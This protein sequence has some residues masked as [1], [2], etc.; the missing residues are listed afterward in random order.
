MGFKQRLAAAP[1]VYAPGAYDAITARMIERA[2]FEAI[3]MTGASIAAASL[4]QPDIGLV[5]FAEVLDVVMRVRDCV[6][7][8]LV[9]DADNGYGNALNVQR[10]VRLLERAGAT[11]IQ[12]EDQTSPKRCGHLK[13]KDVISADEMVGKLRAALDA[14][15]SEETLIIARTDAIAV[16]GF[17]AA[18]D[19]V[20]RFVEAGADI[21]FVEALRTAEE[22]KVVADRFGDRVPLMINMVEGGSTPLKPVAELSQMNFR[23]VIAPGAIMRAVLPVMEELLADM[24]RD[25]STVAWRDRMID[26]AGMNERVELERLL[27]TGRRYEPHGHLQD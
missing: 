8:P 14:R 13:G 20:E 24:R 1:A 9:V 23:L 27:A 6:S 7:L 19:R 22:M 17:D 3:F 25:G 18:I 10:T 12:L 16:A 2:G 26:L 11:A 21:L 4:G 5:S 15:A